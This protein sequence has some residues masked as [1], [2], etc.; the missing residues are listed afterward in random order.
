VRGGPTHMAYWCADM[1]ATAQWLIGQGAEPVIAPMLAP[2]GENE[3]LAGKAFLDVLAKASACYLR[4]PAGGVVELNPATAL[5]YM[6][7]VW[8]EGVLAQVPASRHSS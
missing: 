5:G 7:M 1:I 8:G 6:P 2:P 4:L 3:G